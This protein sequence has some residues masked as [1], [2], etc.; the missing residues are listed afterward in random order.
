MRTIEEKAHE[1]YKEAT[2]PETGGE[3]FFHY[4]DEMIYSQGFKEGYNAAL[5]TTKDSEKEL[6]NLRLKLKEANEKCS[7]LESYSRG[8]E[9]KVAELEVKDINFLKEMRE[10]V[11]KANTDVTEFEMVKTMIEDWIN[12]LTK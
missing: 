5:E 2:D 7:S 9:L 11:L 8:L 6:I 1:A 3:C 10:H 12:E 4:T